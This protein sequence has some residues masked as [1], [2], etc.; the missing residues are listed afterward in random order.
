MAGR[1]HI[2]LH[3]DARLLVRKTKV[4]RVV[5]TENVFSECEPVALLN[6]GGMRRNLPL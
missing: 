2:T 6:G 1:L 5:R 3:P 4:R